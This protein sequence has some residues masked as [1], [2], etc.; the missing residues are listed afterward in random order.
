MDYK[1]DILVYDL[2]TPEQVFIASF[3]IIETQSWK[4]YIIS[5]YQND[6]YDL[7]QFLEDNKEKYFCGYNCLKFDGQVIEYIWRT[8][9]NWAD[10][11][12]LEI[13]KLISDFGSNEIENSNYGL[14]NSF[15]ETDFTFKQLDLPAIWH[16]FNEKKRVGLKQLEFEIR[17]ETIAN[18]EIRMDQKFSPEEV[19]ELVKYCHNDVWY[20]YI[21][22]LF[23]IGETTHKLYKGKDKLKDRQIIINEVGLPCINWDDVKIGAEWNKKDYLEVSGRNEKELKPKKVNHYYG[24]KFKQFFPKTVEFQSKGVKDFVKKF[25]DS[26]I[27]REKIEYTYSFTPKLT[28]SLGKGGIHSQ[29]K[30]RKIQ[31][32]ENT[33]YIQADIGSQYPNAIRKLHVYP[34]HL[35]KE[36]Y[37]MIIEKIRRRIKYKGLYKE[38]KDPKYNSLQEMGKLSLNGGSYGRLGLKGDWQEDPCAL[39]EVTIG[40]QLEILMIGEALILKGFEVVS[41]N[42][43][44]FDT[45]VPKDRLQ[46]YFDICNYYEKKIGNE[47]MGNLEYTRF[48]W[49]L[50]TSVNSYLAK[51]LGE[52]KSNGEF[53]PHYSVDKDD[54]YKC[55]GEFEYWK[56][57]NKNSSFSIIPYTFLEYYARGADVEEV[58]NN[59]KDIFDFCARSSSGKTYYHVDTTNST[60]EKQVVL[61]KIIRY[62][63]S[64]MVYI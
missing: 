3:Y 7:I 28:I 19:E 21:H 29:E 17:A 41:F 61:P 60:L 31:P 4:D 32:D 24:K 30:M 15:R 51:K 13:T 47:E 49:I 14:F 64:R 53:K 2:E 16:F 44:G 59:H 38:T 62:Y 22:F 45:L 50:Q 39:L 6:L 20:T 34:K 58:I 46:E 43:D 56:E 54:E 63:V 52:Y 23:T 48:E 10:L 37:E 9:S 27:S 18:F 1:K 36:W 12:N 8:Y 40:C 26:T 11:T 35:G 55:K 5:E 42:T 33:L 25:G 57:L